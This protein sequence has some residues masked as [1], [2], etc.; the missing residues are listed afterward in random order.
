MR[1]RVCLLLVLAVISVYISLFSRSWY[2]LSWSRNSPCFME[3]ERLCGHV[4]DRFHN[5]PPL[6]LWCSKWSLSTRTTSLFKIQLNIT[7][8]F[9]LRSSN[10]TPSFRFTTGSSSFPFLALCSLIL[11]IN[12]YC[13]VQQMQFVTMQYRQKYQQ[14]LVGHTWNETDC[15]IQIFG[16]TVCRHLQLW[17]NQCVT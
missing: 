6:V 8:P 3:R 17:M 12:I 2:F 10:W 9:T 16:S 14:Q 7:L 5:S 13:G 1:T 15:P 4:H 11:Q